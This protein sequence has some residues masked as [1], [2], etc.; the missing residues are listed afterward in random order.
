MTGSALVRLPDAIAWELRGAWSTGR[1]VALSLAADVVRVEGWV[2]SVSPTGGYAVVAGLHV[3][4]SRVL[5]VHRPSR[6]GDS[7]YREG[8]GEPWTGTLPPGIRRDPDQLRL[9][10]LD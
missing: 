10:G 8:S 5:A 4:L 9:P 7:T 6:L 1:R 3:P 2:S